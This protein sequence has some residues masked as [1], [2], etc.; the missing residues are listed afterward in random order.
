MQLIEEKRVTLHD[1]HNVKDADDFRAVE[2]EEIYE[3]IASRSVLGSRQCY[4]KFPTECT[5]FM[6]NNDGSLFE[7]KV[8]FDL[9]TGG[10]FLMS[11]DLTDYDLRGF[12]LLISDLTT[13]SNWEEKLSLR[14]LPGLIV[15][16]IKGSRDGGE[17]GD[18]I[19]KR[20]SRACMDPR[21]PSLLHGQAS[22]CVHNHDGNDE[23]MLLLN[24]KI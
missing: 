3:E 8:D 22:L 17:V 9:I 12:I 18:R 20:T 23:V 10:S 15:K 24:T 4:A 19:P 13:F 2:V 6:D 5:S 7:R 1:K 11:K 16:F 21:S 14:N